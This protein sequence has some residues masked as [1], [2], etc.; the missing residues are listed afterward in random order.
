MDQTAV[1]EGGVARVAV[2]E[3]GVSDAWRRF[4][5][6]RLAVLASRTS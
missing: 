5:R 6:N 3:R 1:L 2:A 4:R